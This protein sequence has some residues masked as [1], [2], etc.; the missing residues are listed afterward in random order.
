MSL[1]PT[2]AS[3]CG[4]AWLLPDTP[5]HL[6]RYTLATYANRIRIPAAQISPAL[7]EML[8][9]QPLGPLR[10]EAE[11]AAWKAPLRGVLSASFSIALERKIVEDRSVVGMIRGTDPV[12]KDEA[13]IVSGHYDHNGATAEQIFAGADDNA[14]GAIATIEIAEAYMQAAAKGQRPSSPRPIPRAMRRPGSQPGWLNSFAT[15]C[16]RQTWPCSTAFTPSR[17]PMR[18]R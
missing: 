10:K 15:G 3:A 18:P 13:I 6:E 16:R 4:T 9:G 2:R 12:L 1:A 8:L 14:S 5:P 7:A 11:A 17:P